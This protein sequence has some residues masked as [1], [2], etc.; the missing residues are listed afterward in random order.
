[1]SIKSPVLKYYGSKFR[2]A[3][4]IISHFPKHRHYVEPF[5]G[6]ANVLL[7][8]EQSVL[9][10]YNDLNGDIVHFF[11][12]LRDRPNE[13]IRSIR[14]TPWARQ[15]YE[16]CCQG[17]QIE[18]PVERSRRLFYRLWMSIQG[19]LAC[20]SSFRRHNKGRRSVTR[21][22]RPR[23][24]YAASKRLRNVVIENRDAFQ[25]IAETDSPDTLF[26]LDPPYLAETRTAS[27]VYSHEMS[28]E[29][30]CKFID[31]LKSLRGSVILSGYPSP[32][33]KAKLE[34]LGWN[35]VD[36]RAIVNNGGS[37][38]ESLWFSPTIQKA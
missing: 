25:L 34:S 8:K 31:L 2:L 19:G 6:A 21:D 37:R 7:V 4:W 17:D 24:L 35:R 32:L 18:D 10:T 33:Y 14:L 11:R 12:I 16:A 36:K 22:I 23:D 20:R 5:G 38:I 15:E 13:L 3:K 30:H 29:A 9:E 28:D 27:K 26:Y 1:M